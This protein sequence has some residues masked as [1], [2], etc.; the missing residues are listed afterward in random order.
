[1]P[2]A[3]PHEEKEAIV[4]I[5][6]N[7][8]LSLLDRAR[9]RDDQAW[10]EIVDLYSP[11]V[12]RWCQRSHANPEATADCIQEVF[13]AVSRSLD[14][15]H[16]QG[17][18]GAFRAWLWAITRNK[19]RD[20]VRRNARNA[21]PIGGSTALVNLHQIPEANAISIEEPSDEQDV[22]LLIGRAIKQIE[23]NFESQ[24]WQ[25]FWRTTVDGIPTAVV[26]QQLGLS[27]ASIRQARSRVLRRL[28]QQLGDLE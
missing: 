10:R 25:A 19:L 16:P 23:S 7:T 24:T 21:A 8:H 11:T 20:A 6:S 3:V 14:T 22:Q 2:S 4:V 26:A 1:L 28:R 15:F 9:N 18:S 12:V 17:V 27:A 5:S 13:A